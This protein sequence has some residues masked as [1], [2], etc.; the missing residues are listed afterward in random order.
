MLFC[1]LSPLC[2]CDCFCKISICPS[3]PAKSLRPLICPGHKASDHLWVWR[4]RIH[5]QSNIHRPMMVVVTGLSSIVPIKRLI[6][7]QWVA[8]AGSICFITICDFVLFVFYTIIQCFSACMPESKLLFLCWHF[9]YETPPLG[10]TRQHQQDPLYFPV[11]PVVFYLGQQ[12]IPTSDS[13]DGRHILRL[14]DNLANIIVSFLFQTV[15]F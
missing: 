8:P 13:L 3:S 6:H 4:A 7:M 11:L 1:L 14:V 15:F 2:K 10:G 9:S 5:R 12:C